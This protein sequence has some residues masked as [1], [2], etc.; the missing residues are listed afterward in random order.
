MTWNSKSGKEV[1]RYIKLLKHFKQPL[2]KD[3]IL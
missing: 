2:L 3:A 1:S